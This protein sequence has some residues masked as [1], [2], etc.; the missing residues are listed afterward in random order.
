M[1]DRGVAPVEGDAA[2]GE[3]VAGVHVGVVE[4]GGD[5]QVVEFRAPLAQPRCQ[6]AQCL[7]LAAGNA[8]RR[9]DRPDDGGVVHQSVE[10]AGN[11]GR[12]QIG[13]AEGE[14]PGGLPRQ[15]SLQLPVA[16]QH[17]RPSAAVRRRRLLLAQRRPAVA[18]Q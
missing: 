14:Q 17:R 4:A 8:V 13:Q 7:M 2:G 9:V 15:V 1:R 16:A 3:D 18:G 11:A 10:L 5:A 12:A 6:R